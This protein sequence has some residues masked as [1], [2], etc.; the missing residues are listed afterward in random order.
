MK[1]MAKNAAEYTGV[2][3][4]SRGA[5]VSPESRKNETDYHAFS[6]NLEDD[7]ISTSSSI[8]VMLNDKSWNRRMAAMVDLERLVGYATKN[9]LDKHLRKIYSPLLTTM[10][11]SNQEISQKGFQ[12]M[13]SLVKTVGDRIAPYLAASIPKMLLKMG[14]CKGIQKE[15]MG[16][17]KD[18]MDTFGT[19]EI[20]TEVIKNGLQS[21][22]YHVRGESINVI[23]SGLISHGKINRLHIANDLAPYMA[24]ASAKVRQACFEAMALITNRLVDS[25]LA[26]VVAMVGSVHKSSMLP[27]LDIDEL[28]LMDAF[29]ARLARNSVP[30]LDKEGLVKYSIPVLSPGMTHVG[31]D[32]DWITAVS[33]SPPQT[34]S[35]SPPREQSNDNSFSGATDL[36]SSFRPYR[37]A[38]KRPWELEERNEVG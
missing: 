33:V 25:E 30:T 20:V 22:S 34:D 17:F 7:I 21:K 14:S 31:A 18:L 35:S 19:M 26:Q 32:V 11:D 38:G 36:S 24:D 23:I 6:N 9:I 13:R 1:D 28:N 15:G 29:H 16:V 2:R 3:K 10:T 5:Y 27:S 12:L 8:E 4:W 37:S